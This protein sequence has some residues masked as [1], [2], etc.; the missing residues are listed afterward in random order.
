MFETVQYWETR[1]LKQSMG[2]S[3]WL[4][5]DNKLDKKFENRRSYVEAHVYLGLV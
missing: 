5:I 3:L 1:V 4:T 2:D